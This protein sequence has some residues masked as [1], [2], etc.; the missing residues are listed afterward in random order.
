MPDSTKIFISV[1]LLL[2]VLTA[3]AQFKNVLISDVN[4]PNETSI[5]MDPLHP[6]YLVAGANLNNY[7]A[8]SDSG[9]TWFRH[10]LTSNFYGVWGD[11]AM[12]VD[13]FGNFYFFH[14]SNPPS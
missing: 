7:Y 11:P 14:L 13:A 6:N 12:T 8:S 5:M 3:N 2:L 9:K 10:L 1:V 4:N